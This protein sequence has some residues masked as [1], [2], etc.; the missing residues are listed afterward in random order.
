MAQANRIHVVLDEPT[1][2][3]IRQALGVLRTDLVP[4][5]LD[6]PAFR[7]DLEALALLQNLSRELAPVQE[8]LD[9][10]IL[11]C[12]S[13]AYQAALLFYNNLKAAQKAHVASAASVY[14]DLAARF[15]GASPRRA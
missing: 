10:S 3:R 2:S 13:E 9:D 1:L 14:E 12:G 11:L 5:F 8:A 15:P 4:P 7:V 6:V